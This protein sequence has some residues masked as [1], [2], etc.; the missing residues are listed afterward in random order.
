MAYAYVLALTA[1]KKGRISLLDWGGGLGQYCILSEALLPEV[2]IEYHCH[3]FPLFCQSGRALLP[4]ASFYDTEDASFA[5]TYDLVLASG[6]L[7]YSE[8]WQRVF[9][10]LASVARSHLYITRL[11]IVHQSRSFVTVQRPY[12]LGYR[13]E[14]PGW[15]LSRREVLDCAAASRMEL[16]REFLINEQHF[17]HGA[18]EQGEFRG[19][20]FRSKR[21][22]MNK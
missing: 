9:Q 8:D 3:D 20:L 13:T 14:L 11:P 22:Q 10:R 12:R 7:H 16:V 19:F 6:S 21:E 17:I 5:R 4:D 15:F 18:P 1:Q 2:R